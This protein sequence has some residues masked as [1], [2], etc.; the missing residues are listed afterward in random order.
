MMNGKETRKTMGMTQ[1]LV[2]NKQGAA[3]Q[4]VVIGSSIAGLM[5]AQVLLP[6]FD[7]VTIIDRD[8]LPETAEFRSG[9]PQA[10]HPHTLLRR[11]QLILEQRFPGLTNE[12]LAQGAIGVE[13]Q[14][15]LAYFRGGNWRAPGKHEDTLSIACSRP[16]LESA[17][18]RRVAAHPRVT[19]LPAHE[20]ASL[21]ID[22]R[23]GQVNGVQVRSRQQPLR[24]NGWLAADLVIDASGRQ[25]HAP[26]WLA[27]MGYTPPQELTINARMG[28]ASRIYRR[29][30]AHS[31]QWQA[32]YVQ[33]EAPAQPGGGMIM[34]M[35]GDR[36]HVTLIGMGGHYPPTGEAEFLDY[37]RKL[38]TPELYEAI[39]E[40]EP[41]T[42]PIGYRR[43]ESRLRAYDQLPHYLE[44]FLVYGD[45]VMAMNPL[46]A[47][48]MTAVA[49][50]SLALEK[51]LQAH[52]P[53]L[54]KGCVIGL[55]ATFQKELAAILHKPWQ[56]AWRQDSRWEVGAA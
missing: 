32:M 49:L 40:A 29:P 4:A 21:S 10:R 23:R 41:L 50:G 27:E 55:A 22:G 39:A 54:T 8:R 42:K 17:I 28:Y 33:P 35:E 38:S 2:R 52:C 7:G 36:W 14:R 30:A 19:V 37:A 5:A 45:A 1:P 18:Y 9:V 24:E 20:A 3:G 26:K 53:K 48:G 25:S 51:A 11:G 6:F 34:P 56:M 46:Y 47:Q 31:K 15:E 16:L 13:A 43:T 44:G 12:L